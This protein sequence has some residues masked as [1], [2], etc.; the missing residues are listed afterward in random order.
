MAVWS[1]PY[2]YGRA[3]CSPGAVN[4]E[5]SDMYGKG[6]MHMTVQDLITVLSFG[7]TCFSIG[8]ALGI[9]HPTKK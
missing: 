8:Y 7:L 3:L 1:F 2:S 5:Q 6:G 4:A 9:N